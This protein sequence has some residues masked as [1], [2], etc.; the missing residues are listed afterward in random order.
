MR[1]LTLLLDFLQSFDLIGPDCGDTRRIRWDYLTHGMY[2]E[3]CSIG[4]IAFQTYLEAWDLCATRSTL[5]Y[6]TV[7]N[8]T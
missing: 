7:Q 4:Q 3:W 2:A 1:L 6:I 5:R 8:L